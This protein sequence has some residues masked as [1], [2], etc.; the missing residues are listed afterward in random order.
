MLVSE[1]WSTRYISSYSIT[2]SFLSEV[3]KTP[4]LA[5]SSSSF[6]S[7]KLLCLD[8]PCLL[9]KTFSPSSLI[10]VVSGLCAATKVQNSGRITLSVTTIRFSLILLSKCPVSLPGDLKSYLH[11]SLTVLSAIYKM[12]GRW[13]VKLLPGTQQ[14]FSSACPFAGFAITFTQRASEVKLQELCSQWEVNY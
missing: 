12:C 10:Q 2:I 4:N 13:G 3:K 9:S 14:C 6:H 11:K 8:L 7:C 5:W 1:N